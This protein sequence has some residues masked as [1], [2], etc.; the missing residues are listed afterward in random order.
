MATIE[1]RERD[2]IVYKYLRGKA[3]RRDPKSGKYY[4]EMNNRDLSDY[5][6]WYDPKYID[7]I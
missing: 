3:V 1:N 7:F 4:V 2:V 6:G 5:D